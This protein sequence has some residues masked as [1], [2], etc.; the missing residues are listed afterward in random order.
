MKEETNAEKSAWLSTKELEYVI[1]TLLLWFLRYV[2][3]NMIANL[4][5]QNTNNVSYIIN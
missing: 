2:F 3:A 1:C 5:I 4:S